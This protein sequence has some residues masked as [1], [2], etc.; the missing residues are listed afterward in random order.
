MP[1]L[2]LFVEGHL[3]NAIMGKGLNRSSKGD[4]VPELGQGEV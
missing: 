3:E 2:L 4:K 1:D